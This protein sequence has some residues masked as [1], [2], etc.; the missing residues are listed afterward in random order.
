MRLRARIRRVT[1]LLL[2]GFTWVACSS[3]SATP[4][5]PEPTNPSQLQPPPSGQGVQMMTDAFT[6]SA[7]EEI[8]ACYF[9]KVSNLL[10]ERG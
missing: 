6:V 9:F 8:Q 10:T 3:H 5:A 4:T 7:G 1:A 2:F